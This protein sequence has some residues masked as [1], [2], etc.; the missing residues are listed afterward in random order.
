MFSARVRFY[1]LQ[2]F[3]D[4]KGHLMFD[5]IRKRM[6]IIKIIKNDKKNKNYK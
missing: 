5:R 4:T 3:G 2:L 6:I 1:K